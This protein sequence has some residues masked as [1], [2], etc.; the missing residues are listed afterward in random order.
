MNIIV[1]N[2]NVNNI[3]KLL[4]K[5]ESI[6]YHFCKDFKYDFNRLLKISKKDKIQRKYIKRLSSSLRLLMK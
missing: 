5:T 2:L 3:I 4:M 1:Y 6:I